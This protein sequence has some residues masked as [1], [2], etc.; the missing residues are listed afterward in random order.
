MDFI[1]KVKDVLLYKLVL[2][3]VLS[4]TVLFGQNREFA[5]ADSIFNTLSLREKAGQMIIVYKSPYSF[6]KQHNIGAVL[7]MQNM[8]RKHKNLKIELDS[9]QRRL[10]I[11]LLVTIDQE[12]GKVNRVSTIKKFKNV[13]SA[14][15]LS[16]MNGKDIAEYTTVIGKTLHDLN[17]NMNLAPVLDPSINYLGKETFIAHENRSFGT[18]VEDIVSPVKAFVAGFQNH[19]VFCISKH[20]P[21]Y[22][23]ETNS[24]HDIAISNAP[25]ENIQKNVAVFEAMAPYTAGIMM[26]SIHFTQYCKTPAVLCPRMVQWA[27]DVAGDKVIMTDDLWGTALRSFVHPGKK[28]HISKYP[29]KPFRKLIKMTLFAGNDMLMITFPQ[30]ALIMIDEIVKQA[31]AD[32]K[33]MNHVNSAV[34]RILRTKEEMGLF[35]RTNTLTKKK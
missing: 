2:L 35:D 25:L 16:K 1:I 8:M 33:V 12:G 7:I 34:K 19:S 18:G 26:S 14:R 5:K 4:V 22:D 10:P 3:V 6:L 24:D 27:R 23:A 20:F 21:G 17:V 28:I 31:K 13:K 11:P 32:P 29:E 30:K 9:M 15:E